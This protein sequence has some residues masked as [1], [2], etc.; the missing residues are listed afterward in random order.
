MVKSGEYKNKN[1]P[2]KSAECKKFL[3]WNLNKNW[4][5]KFA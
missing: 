3:C 2:E 1:W 4:A 5:E